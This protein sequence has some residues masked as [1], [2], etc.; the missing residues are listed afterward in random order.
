[1]VQL[2][3]YYFRTL[4]NLNFST[5]E[6]SPLLNGILSLIFD[7]KTYCVEYVEQN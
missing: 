7:K 4:F 2:L 1:M 5:L 6:V 3:K